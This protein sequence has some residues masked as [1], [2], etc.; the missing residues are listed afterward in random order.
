MRPILIASVT[1]R[2]SHNTIN[3]NKGLFS[4]A[5]IGTNSYEDIWGTL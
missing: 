4:Y 3:K 2:L 1:D 5:N